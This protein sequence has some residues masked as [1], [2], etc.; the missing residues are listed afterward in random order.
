M[1]RPAVGPGLAACQAGGTIFS[2]RDATSSTSRKV[3]AARSNEMGAPE[4]GIEIRLAKC[5]DAPAQGSHAGTWAR[6]A[7][8]RHLLYNARRCRTQPSRHGLATVIRT[9]WLA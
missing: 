2:G 9:G 8:P 6:A 3:A 1:K 7:P 5:P 4:N